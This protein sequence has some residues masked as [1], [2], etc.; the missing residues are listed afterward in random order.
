IIRLEVDIPDGVN[1]SLFP[2]LRS[3]T[4]KRITFPQSNEL[5]LAH[6]P[7]LTYFSLLS[8][9][10]DASSYLAYQIFSNWFPS[11]RYVNLSGVGMPYGRTW[12]PSPN[13]RSVYAVCSD[14]ILLSLIP[15]ACPNLH[16]L[17]VKLVSNNCAIDL[18]SSYNRHV[19]AHPLK[20]FILTDSP[21]Y[22]CLDKIDFLFTFLSNIENLNLLTHDLPFYELVLVLI[23][24]LPHLRRFD[25]NIGQSNAQ[26][27][28]NVDID[29]IRAIRP[30]FETCMYKDETNTF[31]RTISDDWFWRGFT[32]KAAAE[33]CNNPD[34]LQ[35]ATWRDIKCVLTFLIFKERFCN[36]YQ[37]V[38]IENGFIRTLLLRVKELAK[39]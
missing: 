22:L 16:R 11:L 18:P 2:N 4:L 34:K 29:T 20:H 7:H 8:C 36:G 26:Q 21:G 15:T 33:Y 9:G 30:C 6:L 17:E 3:L 24:R 28:Q 38:A 10:F 27:S 32:V 37:G 1:W 31:Y 39:K 12:S 5:A 13:L 23:N 14:P 35:T 19:Q 25:C